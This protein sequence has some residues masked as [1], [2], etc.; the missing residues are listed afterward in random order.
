MSKISIIIAREYL[1]RVRKK[2]FLLTTLVLPIVMA[3]AFAGIGYVSAKSA[4]ATKIAVVDESGV[5]ENNLKSEGKKMNF[6]IFDKTALD[7]LKINYAA[8]D[9]KALLHIKPLINNK[10]DTNSIHLYIEST[11][12]VEATNALN[13]KLNTIYQNKIMADGGMSKTE[14]DSI[15]NLKI[16]FKTI[17]ADEKSIGSDVASGIGSVT[18]FLIYLTIFIYGTMVMRGVMEEKTN[19]IAEIIVSSVKPFELMMGKVIGIGLVGLTQFIIWIVFTS[20]LSIAAMSLGGG[21]TSV[22]IPIGGGAAAAQAVQQNPEIIA[23]AIAKLQ[24]INITKILFCFL[25]YFL[26]G[27]LLYAS[28][29]AAV[30]SLV[31]EDA[32]EAQSLTLPITMPIILGFVI[33]VQAA[34]D[35]NSSIAVFGSIFPLTAPIVMMARIGYNPPMWQIALSMVLLLLTFMFTVFLAGKIYRTGILMYGKKLTWKD[36]IKWVLN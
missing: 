4:K 11:L 19:R 30:G 3:A 23:M 8:K 20:I 32:Q 15:N 21:A 29:F 24:S 9:F 17:S 35:P 31:N 1:S 27:Y 16:D 22:N 2:S 28:L 18:G 7:S 12:G 6:T 34:Q 36:A 25:F 33:A 14:I 13:N 5:F 26:G 10:P